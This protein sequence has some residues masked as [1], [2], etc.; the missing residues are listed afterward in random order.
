MKRLIKLAALALVLQIFLGGSFTFSQVTLKIPFKFEADGKSYPPGNYRF[1][2][3]EEGKIILQSE[4]GTVDVLIPI[5][6]KIS[7]SSAPIEAPQLIFD[8][9]ANFKPSYTEYVTD[10]LLA[11]V[12][13]TEKDGF[14]VLSGER[15]EYT[16]VVKGGKAKQ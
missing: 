8:M 5:I 7:Q 2:Q 12:W 3:G 6:E 1:A 9:V 13:V 4:S 16:Q 14:L 15:S 11:E 10:Y